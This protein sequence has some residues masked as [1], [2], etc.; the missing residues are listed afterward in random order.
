MAV[1]QLVEIL[2]EIRDQQRQQAASFDKALAS[3]AEH[4]AFQRRS[5][6]MFQFLVFAPWVMLA[7]ALAYGLVMAHLT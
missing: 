3:Q 5:R 4:L 1:E 6:P 7:G 2:T